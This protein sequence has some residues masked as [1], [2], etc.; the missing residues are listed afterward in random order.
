MA[1]VGYKNTVG[2]VSFKCGGSIISKRHVLTGL[3]L[4]TFAMIH[5]ATQFA[6]IFS[7]SLHPQRFVS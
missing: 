7:C 2:D 4:L 3:F 1:L 6:S 5:C